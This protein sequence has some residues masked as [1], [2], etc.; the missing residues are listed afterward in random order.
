MNARQL[1]KLDGELTAYLDSMFEGMGRPERREAMRQYATGLLL[2]GD[3]KSMEPMASRLAADVSE[4]EAMRQ[5]L[6]ECV[7]VSPWHEEE[8]WRRLAVKVDAELPDLEAMVVDDTGFPKKGT[9]SVGVQRQ[10]SGTLGRKDNCQIAVSLHLAGERG[11]ACIGMRL[12]LPESWASDRARCRRA[13][14]PDEVEFR[15]KWELS[16][17]QIDAALRWGVRPR[18]VLG[19]A[20]YGDVSEYREGLVARKLDYVLGV[21][22]SLVV[23]APGTGPMAPPAER[24]KGQAGR[25]PCRWKTGDQ[26]PLTVLALATSRGPG[27]CR[28]VHW[29]EGSRGRQQSRFGAVRIRTA[30]RHTQGAPPGEEQWLFYEWP[31]DEQAPT[32]FWFSTLPASTSLKRLVYLAKLRW[33]VERD[34]QELKQ[35]VGLDHFEGRGWRG[36]HHHAALCGVA[37][38]FLALRRALSPP[39]RLAVDAP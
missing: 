2:D 11:S 30:H 34:Y 22:G 3:R 13:G 9:H 12:Y 16:L 24:P 8:V 25:M 36:F 20:G 10:Y 5:R 31:A 38:G 28:T 19:D 21:Q 23:W 39:E 4:V 17:A 33:R 14:V 26:K 6:Q 35:E 37:H 18:V 15:R 1:K 7:S 27:A 29:R 32:K